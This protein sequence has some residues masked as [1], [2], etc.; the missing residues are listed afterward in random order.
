M[1]LEPL[2]MCYDTAVRIQTE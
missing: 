1:Q 2:L